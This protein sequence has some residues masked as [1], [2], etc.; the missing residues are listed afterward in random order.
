VHEQP[1]NEYEQPPNEY[2]H[3]MNVH[4]HSPHVHI[5]MARVHPRSP[6]VFNCKLFV[7]NELLKKNAILTEIGL[8]GW[9][10]FIFG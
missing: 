6:N 7:F 4:T 9:R 8:P 1:P 2:E 3:S 5:Q 10:F